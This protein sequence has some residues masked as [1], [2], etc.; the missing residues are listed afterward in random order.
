MDK[1]L[2]KAKELKSAIDETPEMQD[3]LRY[4]ELLENS[5][6]VIELKHNI[7]N[8]RAQGKMQEADNL[9]AL[10]NNHPIVVN[11]LASKDALSSLLK[12]IESII[13]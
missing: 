11:Y 10:Y 7:A 8:L 13:K 3:Y 6:D 4:K 5:E 12:T 9:Q 2:E 1:V